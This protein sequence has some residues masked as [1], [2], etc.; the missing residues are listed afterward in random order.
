MFFLRTFDL[1]RTL[2]FGLWTLDLTSQP[3]EVLAALFEI[4]IL[5]E[6]SAGRRK[7]HGVSRAG[8]FG[9]PADGLL[10]CPGILDLHDRGE[11]PLDGRRRLADREDLPRRVG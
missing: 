8:G 3:R 4:P 9:R 7:E 1:R 6:R 11:D 2:D 5:V 10:H